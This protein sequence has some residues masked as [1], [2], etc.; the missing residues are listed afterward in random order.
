MKVEVIIRPDRL[1]KLKTALEERGFVSMTISEVVGRGEQKGIKL[2]YNRRTK[3]GDLLSKVRIE[4]VVC[5][6]EVDFLIE[7]IAEAIRTGNIG[8]G[9]IFVSPVARSIKL[10]SGEDIA[11]LET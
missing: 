9:R 2:R 3:N 10:R 7:T 1:E 8:D 4:L 5:D 11:R 6:Y